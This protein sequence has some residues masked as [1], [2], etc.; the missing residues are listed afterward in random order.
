MEREKKR[1]AMSRILR[2][3]VEQSVVVA[4]AVAFIADAYVYLLLR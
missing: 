2:V 3:L 4:I 1:R